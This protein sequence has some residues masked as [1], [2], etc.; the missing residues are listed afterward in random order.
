MK[1]TLVISWKYL[2][3]APESSSITNVGRAVYTTTLARLKLYDYLEK[4][5]ERVLYYDTDSVIY[6][7]SKGQW[8]PPTG[9][10]I[11][12]M[13]DELQG[14]FGT[15]SYIDEFVSGGPKNY[16]YKV[17]STSTNGHNVITKEEEK[18]YKITS[19]KRKF[20]P[21]FSSIPYG[22]KKIK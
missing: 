19:S 17:N 8:E 22:Y 21:D 4:L 7:T 18:Q 6:I 5:S 20:L 1:K 3:E 11:C 14:E 15:G 2:N 12:D 16:A 10:L 9:N 13:T